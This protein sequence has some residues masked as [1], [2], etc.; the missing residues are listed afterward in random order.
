MWQKDQKTQFSL[1][2]HILALHVVIVSLNEDPQV[3]KICLNR[4]INIMIATVF[5]WS[6]SGYE[7]AFVSGGGSDVWYFWIYKCHWD[8]QRSNEGVQ[9]FCVSKNQQMRSICLV[10]VKKKDFST[11]PYKFMVTQAENIK[12]IIDVNSNQCKWWDSLDQ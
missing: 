1:K 9:C 7:F 8:S 6:I 12:K 4:P 3:L 11:P 10:V 5:G 2:S